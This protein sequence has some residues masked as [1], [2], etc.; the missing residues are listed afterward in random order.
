MATGPPPLSLLSLLLLLLAAAADGRL[1]TVRSPS[2]L[3]SDG[4]SLQQLL[5]LGSAA[6]CATR[7]TDSCRAPPQQWATSSSSPSTAT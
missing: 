2:D 1:I 6:S 4:V 3:V 5:H 7:R